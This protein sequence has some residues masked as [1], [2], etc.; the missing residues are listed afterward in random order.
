[1]NDTLNRHQSKCLALAKDRFDVFFRE[2]FPL[3]R[4]A[5]QLPQPFW[6]G[7]KSNGGWSCCS[8]ALTARLVSA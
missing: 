1:M 2:I 8:A 7:G 3:A 6:L 4:N 5:G